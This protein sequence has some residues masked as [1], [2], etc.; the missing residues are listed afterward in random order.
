MNLSWFTVVV[1]LFLAVAV[2]FFVVA[3]IIIRRLKAKAVAAGYSGVH[4]YL[5]AAPRNDEEKMEA[6]DMVLK[7]AV[8]FITG[9][10][11]PPLIL[12]GLFPFYYG[13]RK[14]CLTSFGLGPMENG[15]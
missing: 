13:T 7:G 4:E 8:L 15:E 9:L 3:V 2:S 14:L 11:F 12:L 6:V 1:A 10:I 5:R